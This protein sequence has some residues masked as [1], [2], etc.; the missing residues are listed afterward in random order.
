ME[1]NT[2]DY[3]LMVNDHVRL[4]EFPEDSINGYGRIEHIFPD[5]KLRIVNLNMPYSGTL[6]NYV[7]TPDKVKP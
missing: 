2:H 4:L 6:S 1:K 3:I 5:G 7:V